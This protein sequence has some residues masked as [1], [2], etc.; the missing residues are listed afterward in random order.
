VAVHQGYL[1]SSNVDAVEQMVAM[2]VGF[3]TYQSNQRLV[4]VQDRTL[5]R[6]I[7]EVGRV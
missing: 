2:I 5:E 3:R 4:Q 7:N 1:E 6:L